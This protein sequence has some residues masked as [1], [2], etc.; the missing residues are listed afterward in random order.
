MG[1]SVALIIAVIIIGMIAGARLSTPG[2]QRR[3]VY[4]AF[5]TLAV[6]AIWF[7]VFIALFPADWIVPFFT[8]A[9][10]IVPICIYMG[11]ARSSNAPKIKRSKK[12]AVEIPRKALEPVKPASANAKAVSKPAAEI[13]ASGVQTKSKAAPAPT[14]SKQTVK[15]SAQPTAGKSVQQ[16]PAKTAQPTKQTAKP[17]SGTPSKQATQKAATS[18]SK[19]VATAQQS[20]Q[21]QKT[22]P[23]QTKQAASAQPVKK[24]ETT[25][26]KPAANVQKARS[27]EQPKTTKTQQPQRKP[28]GQKPAAQPQPKQ[29]AQQPQKQKQQA[30][31][32]VAHPE[33]QRPVASKQSQPAPRV[34]QAQPKPA[35]GAPTS[36]ADMEILVNKA[37]DKDKQVL[38]EL[39]RPFLP[40]NEPA[41]APL[42]DQGPDLNLGAPVKK[43][44]SASK[45]SANDSTSGPAGPSAQKATSAK[46]AGSAQ[47][48]APTQQ[49]KA[50]PAD[51]FAEFCKKATMLR[52]QGNYG[53][54]AILFEKA[55]AAASSASDKRAA[56]F[57]V[58]SC[59]V[60][61]NDIPKAKALAAKLRQ[62]S[63][64]TRFERIKLDA[65][66]RMG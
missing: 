66:E 6:L 22:K 27:A 64:L 1:I 31:K 24:T 52:D 35:P 44:N 50:E 60:K 61:A 56:Q 16:A 7:F 34:S 26:Q 45:S 25:S 5:G 23:T 49:K 18:T 19:Q 12:K 38:D 42:A 51:P 53:V 63:V 3:A 46:N 30:A 20:Q 47:V 11:V 33:Q 58:L 41:S 54:A 36:A 55:A 39:V 43:D 13:N 17:V 37:M 14:A 57:D 15:Q 59:Y 10:I 8:V 40:H 9:C 21:A 62:S 28:A 2:P 48:P 29:A 32:P 4:F 65:V